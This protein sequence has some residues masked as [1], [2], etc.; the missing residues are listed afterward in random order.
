MIKF[1]FLIGIWVGC[2]FVCVGKGWLN[3]Y[4]WIWGKYYM[5]WKF[6]KW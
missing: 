5:E 1:D 3:I 6:I 2:I 4:V